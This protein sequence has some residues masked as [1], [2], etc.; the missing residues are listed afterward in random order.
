MKL[1]TCARCGNVLYF[2][3][4]RCEKCSST[5]GY[6]PQEN[7]MLPLVGEGAGWLVLDADG[8]QNERYGTLRSCANAA[9]DACNWLLPESQE[10][11]YCLSCRHNRTVPDLS[12]GN[13]V[14]AWQR[15][16]AAKNRLFYA[17]LRWRL[18]LEVREK[19]GTAGLCFDV[20]PD[21]A[22]GRVMTGHDNGLITLALSEADDVERQRRRLAMGEP[23]RTLLGHVRHEI[24]HYYWDVLVR[25]SDRLD[26]CRALFGDDREDY[27]T[28]LQRYY[29]NGPAPDWHARMV[30]AYASAHPWEDFAETFGHYLHITDTLEMGNAFGLSV[31]PRLRTPD[32]AAFNA[33]LDFDPYRASNFA[34][35]IDS[36]LPLTFVANNLNRCMGETDLYP[37]VLSDGV[38]EKL[39]FIH[40]VV[41]GDWAST[42]MKS[43]HL[44][45]QLV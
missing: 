28:A 23:Y 32:A 8:N 9:H 33:E 37:F 12:D 38:V 2:E 39:A 21:P 22:G 5:L 26:H 36:W 13:Y 25:D 3:N 1:F 19:G 11:D 20:L 17:L 42:E 34:D 6:L 40:G 31:H 4:I 16:Q 15:V 18:K 29:A 44:A 14:A 24:G 35:I 45:R 43:Q 27:G 10:G 30:S 7:R 41:T